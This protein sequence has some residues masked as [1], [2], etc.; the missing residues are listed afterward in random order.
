M[1]EQLE[2]IDVHDIGEG[3][4]VFITRLTARDPW[5]KVER[6]ISFTAG[7]VIPY[8]HPVYDVDVV[9]VYDIMHHLMLTVSPGR[10]VQVKR[11]P[12]RGCS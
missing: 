4:K 6:G 10:R 3:D 11:A 5:D 12:R 1:N 7:S 9:N 2:T 8:R